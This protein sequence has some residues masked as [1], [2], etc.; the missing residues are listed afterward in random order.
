MT[1][2]P[3]KSPPPFVGRRTTADSPRPK[4]RNAVLELVRFWAGVPA[5]APAS[6]GRR[7]EA[8]GVEPPSLR[9]SVQTST[10]LADQYRERVEQ[11]GARHSLLWPRNNSRLPARSPRLRTSPLSSHPA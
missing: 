6:A 2:R 10:C 5:V 11:S 3:N 9:L 1:H 8:R 7:L 4:R